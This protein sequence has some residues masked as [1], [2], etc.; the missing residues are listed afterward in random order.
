M[1][2][3]PLFA[4]VFLL[5]L[6]VGTAFGEKPRDEIPMCQSPCFWGFA[7]GMRYQI[8]PDGP[9][10]VPP[11]AG[12]TVELWFSGTCIATTQTSQLGFYCFHISQ[13]GDYV[14]KL[15]CRCDRQVHHPGGYENIRV[16]FH[17]CIP[18]VNPPVPSDPVPGDPQP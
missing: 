17:G 4:L 1:K 18:C 15:W 16:D 3:Y 11:L 10:V 9:V 2:K 6:L 8:L 7:Y 13:P 14:L 5:L 12:V